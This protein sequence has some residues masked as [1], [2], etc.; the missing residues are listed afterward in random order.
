MVTSDK[1]QYQR[2]LLW[3]LNFAFLSFPL[4]I[5]RLRSYLTGILNFLCVLCSLEYYH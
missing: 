1:T 2:V 5:L 3:N 4:P